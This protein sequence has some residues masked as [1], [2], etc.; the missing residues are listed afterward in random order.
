MNKLVDI[1][2]FAIQKN[3]IQPEEDRLVYFYNLD[4][5]QNKY[6][7]IQSCF[8]SNS[9]HTIPVKT[10]P[11]MGLL[12]L[13]VQNG[14]GLECAS[15]IEFE[16]A[17]KAQASHI[18][19]N[20]P[21]KTPRLIKLL[22][23][24][25]TKVFINVN[26]LKELDQFEQVYQKH[27]ISIRINPLVDIA[28]ANY[29]Q[30]ANQYSKFGHL[31]SKENELVSYLQKY[32]FVSGLHVHTGSNFKDFSPT[33]EGIL[34]VYE[35]AEKINSK[36][37]NPIQSINIGG[38]L[39]A[40][41]D[42]NLFTKQL[43]DKIQPLNQGKYLILTEYGRFVYQDSAFAASVVELIKNQI[44]KDLILSHFGGQAFVREIYTNDKYQFPIEVLQQEE[45]L[46][47]KNYAIAGP[48]CYG[49]DFLIDNLSLPIVKENDWI[50]ANQVG[51]NSL[52]LF[53]KHCSQPFPKVLGFKKQGN[54]LF[55]T[56]LKQKEL[57]ENVINFW[58]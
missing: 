4:F 47:Q 50:I 21:L 17:L 34:K 7:L 43:F 29:L 2:Q 25:H 36:L 33:I 58:E 28:T 5:L 52:G 22:Q 13:A 31:I 38:G 8:P 39:A 32:P 54:Q 19:V 49:G 55:F 56:V 53:S 16:M 14:M 37:N 26:D 40:S 42:L 24:C 45:S 1:L 6:Q 35:L 46:N 27:H 3:Y 23:N 30:T 41:C 20:A 44:D 57:P 11:L 10:A 9:I 48:L 12:K 15:E 18:V 51:G